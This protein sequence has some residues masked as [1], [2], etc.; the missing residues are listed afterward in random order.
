MSGRDAVFLPAFEGG[1][2]TENETL[3]PALLATPDDRRIATTVCDNYRRAGIASLLLSGRAG[4]FLERL[5]KS[6]TAFAFHL[7]HLPD[8]AKRTASSGPLLDAIVSGD[9]GVVNRIRELA[10][11]PWVAAQ[12]YEEDFL[13]YR[14]LLDHALPSRYDEA[15]TGLLERWDACLNGTADARLTVCRALAEGDP[16][17]WSGALEE[18]LDDAGARYEA[19]ADML[20]PEVRATDGAV[21]VQAMAFARLAEER[22]MPTKSTYPGIPSISYPASPSYGER[23][24]EGVG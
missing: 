5:H 17:E 18:Y 9:S 22:G 12:E 19:Q 7:A 10:T 1:F 14:F 4:T 6:A 2:L 13:F 20:P 11:G 24:F 3:V 15:A 16:E 8:S 23:S 21:S